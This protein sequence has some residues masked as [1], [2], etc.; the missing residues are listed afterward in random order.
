MIAELGNQMD[1]LRRAL[2]ALDTMEEALEGVILEERRWKTIENKLS[3]LRVLLEADLERT[4]RT[5]RANWRQ[6]VDGRNRA[7]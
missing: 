2:S 4:E 7:E 5:A 1:A 3:S 6:A